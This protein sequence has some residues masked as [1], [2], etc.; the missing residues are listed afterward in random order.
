MPFVSAANSSSASGLTLPSRS[1]WRCASAARCSA[2]P[3][4]AATAGPPRRRSPARA[5][6]GPY[7]ATRV[8]ASTPNS[9]S[10]CSASCSGAAG[11]RRG[12]SRSPCAVL[13]TV[14]SSA[15]SSRIRARTALSSPA[16]PALAASASA[17]RAS[18][19]HRPL[20]RLGRVPAHRARP[21]GP[22]RPGRR[23]AGGACGP[24]ARG[25]ALGGRG[26]GQRVGAAVDRAQ[27]FLGG[28]D[29]EPGLHLGVPRRGAAVGEVLAA[30]GRLVRRSAGCSS[31]SPSAS[32]SS[33]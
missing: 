9:S 8:S 15:A 23:V 16:P 20:G 3:G 21:R 13:T 27:P 19:G 24:L 17:R 29:L 1:S 26:R 7:S 11:A 31:A 5:P 2:R 33:S 4:R 25:L 22:R 10:A 14:S 12:R 30:A 6:R 32:S 18:A 28:A